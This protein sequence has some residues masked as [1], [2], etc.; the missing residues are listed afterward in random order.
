MRYERNES[1]TVNS[2]EMIIVPE[3]V[4][5]INAPGFHRNESASKINSI[6]FTNIFLL[7]FYY[8][9]VITQFRIDQFFIGLMNK[10]AFGNWNWGS[11]R[12]LYIRLN[13]TLPLSIKINRILRTKKNVLASCI[14]SI[15]LISDYNANSN[16]FKQ[17]LWLLRLFSH[18]H[19]ISDSIKQTKLIITCCF[20]TVTE[21]NPVIKWQTHEMLCLKWFHSI[22]PVSIQ[23]PTVN[24]CHIKNLF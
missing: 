15:E 18:F 14:E 23:K 3:K 13:M 8:I 21:F 16:I 9:R 7:E 24:R 20:F 11:L 22:L 19:W 10:N 2:F 6:N 4:I 1:E 17:F 12:L 5:G